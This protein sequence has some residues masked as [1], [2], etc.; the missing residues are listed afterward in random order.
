MD[1]HWDV[2]SSRSDPA[3][4]RSQ[5]GRTSLVL[6]RCQFLLSPAGAS[7]HLPVMT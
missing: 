2:R 3:V 4:S 5:S 7:L 6:V 1:F